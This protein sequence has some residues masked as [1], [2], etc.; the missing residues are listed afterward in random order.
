MSSERTIGG[1]Y[2]HN[3]EGQLWVWV[4]VFS[5]HKTKER[6]LQGEEKKRGTLDFHPEPTKE[7]ITT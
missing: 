5:L 2:L 4:W 7:F 3:G 1:V 6:M